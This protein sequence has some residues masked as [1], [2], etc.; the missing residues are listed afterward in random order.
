MKWTRWSRR[1]FRW[2]GKRL[3]GQLHKH[4]WAI[5]TPT[6]PE[7][8]IHKLYKETT[9]EHFM[10]KCPHCGRQTELVWPDCVEIVGECSTD[11]RCVESFLKCKECGAKLDHEA[12]PEFLSTAKWVPTAPNANPERRGFHISQLY[13]FTV[14]PGELVVAHLAGR[15]D[16]FAAKEFNNSK[17]GLPF[18]ADGAKVTEA[19]I[20]NAVDDHS[21]DDLRPAR[22]GVRLITMGVDQG[23]Q[24]SYVVVCE[25]LFTQKP[26]RALVRRQSAR[27]CGRD[28]STAR[29]GTGLMS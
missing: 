28:T 24:V 26:G 18:V 12:K 21:M 15:N 7:Y 9:Q 8:G 17:L 13:S 27:F 23:E 29:T 4:E 11:P 3:S 19:M 22:G 1:R 5:S 16:E 6:V 14:T 20:E 2:R 25:W 10:F